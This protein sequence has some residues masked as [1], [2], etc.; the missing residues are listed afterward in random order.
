MS[1]YYVWYDGR[2]AKSREGL[3][4]MGNRARGVV[5]AIIK[6][7]KTGLENVVAGKL[8]CF[9]VF[10]IMSGMPADHSSFVPTSKTPEPRGIL[11]VK[12]KRRDVLCRN[13]ARVAMEAR[14]VRLEDVEERRRVVAPVMTMMQG[15]VW[16]EEAEKACPLLRIIIRGYVIMR[17]WRPKGFCLG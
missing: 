5:E 2:Q 12:E 11:N 1:M 14:D 8:R 3:V 10:G 16:S 15:R 6:G 4:F 17:W 9:V 13:C 7:Y